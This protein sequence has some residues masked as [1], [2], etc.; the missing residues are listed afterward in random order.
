MNSLYSAE[1]LASNNYQQWKPES[2][3]QINQ[4]YVFMISEKISR[5]KNC[6]FRQLALRI[7]TNI[8]A[9]MDNDG[10]VSINARLLSSQLDVHYDTVTKCIKYLKSID[11]IKTER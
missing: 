2:I 3:I 11:V 9:S 4:R 10:K 7:F 5:D 8:L 1:K 6:K